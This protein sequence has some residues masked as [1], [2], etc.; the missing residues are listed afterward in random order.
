MS[1]VEAST[2]DASRAA[3]DKPDR[4]HARL[5][6]ECEN[7]DLGRVR[8]LIAGGRD[9][10]TGLRIVLGSAGRQPQPLKGGTF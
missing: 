7:I 6:T 4:V 9:L 5:L 2:P 8:R 3:C 1:R 10:L